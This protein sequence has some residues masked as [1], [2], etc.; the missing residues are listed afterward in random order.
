MIVNDLI[1]PSNFSWRICVNFGSPIT[2]LNIMLFRV[3][4]SV[5]VVG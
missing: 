2:P 5:S 4:V 3:T 1:V